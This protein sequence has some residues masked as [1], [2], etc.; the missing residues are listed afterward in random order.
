MHVFE[1]FQ[2]RAPVLP[3]ERVL[4]AQSSIE[5]DEYR[6]LEHHFWA[7]NE[8]KYHPHGKLDSMMRHIQCGPIIQ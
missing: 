4:L 1:T 7:D 5:N 8:H 6:Y 2:I 3:T